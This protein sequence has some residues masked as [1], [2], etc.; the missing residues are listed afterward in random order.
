M[1]EQALGAAEVEALAA[2]HDPNGRALAGQRAFDEHHLA[3]GL[4]R[5]AATLGVEA[6]DVENQFF[7]SERNSPQWGRF[8]FSMNVRRRASS[9]SYCS[10]LSA[11]R[12]IW[13]RRKRR[14][15]FAQSV[16]Q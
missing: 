9:A 6:L 3:V 13:K 5:D 11:Q 15:V 12:I 8:C 16:S 10:R 1:V 2:G 4:A 14:Y 7:Q